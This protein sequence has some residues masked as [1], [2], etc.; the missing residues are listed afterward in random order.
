[1][2]NTITL[3]LILCLSLLG[4]TLTQAQTTQALD[5]IVKVN[6]DIIVCRV[7]EINTTEVKYIYPD[8]PGIVLALENE[9]VNYI[10]LSSGE[11]VR[12]ENNDQEI[13]D[14][15]YEK[16][17]TL[18]IKLGIL[19]PLNG[20]TDF[21]F[22]YSRKPLH[23][24]E[25]TL[26]IIGLGTQ[27]TIIDEISNTDRGVT[28]SF[29]YKV[30]A[31]PDF[32]LRK[33]RNAH[34]M[35]GMYVK[36]TISLAYYESVG[37]LMFYDPSAFDYLEEE[38]RTST[39]KAALTVQIGKQYIFGDIFSLDLNVGAGYGI[40]NKERIDWPRDYQE[41]EFYFDFDP[42]YGFNV[43]TNGGGFTLS[44]SLKLGVLI[45]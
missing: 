36:P 12:P 45:K 40:K 7:Q 8:R 38:V 15:A 35:S 34:R 43:F 41:P 1:M 18:N 11:T 29:G 42:G 32:H 26:G 9:L 28:A 4:T 39:V 22:E 19:T 31:G 25:G 6:T 14:L 21:G 30:Y 27:G 33:V 3:L 2:K 5:T 10:R 16:Q 37:D 44:S 24:L 23:S 17:K 20:F 13:S